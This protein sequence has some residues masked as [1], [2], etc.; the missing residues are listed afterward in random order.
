MHSVQVVARAIARI[1]DSAPCYSILFPLNLLSTCP[2]Y[3]CSPL[4]FPFSPQ[5][6]AFE[7]EG[8]KAKRTVQDLSAHRS[9]HELALEKLRVVAKSREDELVDQL[10][11]LALKH[12]TEVSGRACGRDI[13][14]DLGWEGGGIGIFEMG[15]KHAI[16]KKISKQDVI[17]IIFI[18]VLPY[19][20][21]S[22]FFGDVYV[23]CNLL[24][25]R[26][27]STQVSRLKQDLAG[28]EAQLGEQMKLLDSQRSSTL[29]ASTKLEEHEAE[30][31][32]SQR[33]KAR[34]EAA[35]K[36]LEAKVTVRIDGGMAMCLLRNRVRCDATK[37]YAM[38][39]MT[40]YM[41]VML[42]CKRMI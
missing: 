20:F 17:T 11:A 38:N 1:L 21:L 4:F 9:E 5:V 42:K 19:F 41:S 36:D 27:V 3:A 29:Q 12:T 23:L 26:L 24:V 14:L 6:A 32:A 35:N 22:C 31:R 33:Q 40:A 2:F 10:E 7:E 8:R 13:V 39:F 18:L 34:L 25:S 37:F 28:A 16:V 30:V 15:Y